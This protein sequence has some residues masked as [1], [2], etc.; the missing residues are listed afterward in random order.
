M[1]KRL[2]QSIVLVAKPLWF[3]VTWIVGFVAAL[4]PT[5]QKPVQ[6]QVVSTADGAGTTVTT[7]GDQYDIAGGT[8]AGGNLFHEFD[9]FSLEQTQTA[10][11]MSDSGVFN[12]VGESLWCVVWSQC[13]AVFARV[14]YRN[15]SRSGGL[16]RGMV[17]C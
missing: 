13:A 12:I 14:V 17:G 15:H 11:F 6:A 4:F 10:N 16:W 2:Q 7:A 1:E 8:Q 5:S 3:P 9:E